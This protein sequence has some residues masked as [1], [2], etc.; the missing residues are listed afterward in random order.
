MPIPISVVTGL[1]VRDSKILMCQRHRDKPYPYHW[2]FPGGKVEESEMLFQALQR[3]LREELE[4]S[5]SEAEIWFEDI[6]S[7]QTYETYKTYHV[8]F[9]IVRKFTGEPMN[10]EFE[11]IGWFSLEELTRLQHLSGNANILRKIKEEGL[12]K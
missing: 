4:I 9:F 6:M 7:Y 3:E 12:P 2:E 11:E 5:V 10:T 8:T 1:I